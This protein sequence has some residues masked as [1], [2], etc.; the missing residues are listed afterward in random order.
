[1]NIQTFNDDLDYLRDGI[2]N[3]YNRGTHKNIVKLSI[4]LQFK[5]FPSVQK[6]LL[7]FVE[8]IYG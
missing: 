8:E 5:S 6:T 7:F 2:I 3:E 4:A 1:M